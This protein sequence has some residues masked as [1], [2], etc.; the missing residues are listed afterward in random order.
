MKTKFLKLSVWLT[1]AMILAG[2]SCKGKE[3]VKEPD[4]PSL[5]V[6]PEVKYPYASLR[7]VSRYPYGQSVGIPTDSQ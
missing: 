6:T 2:T 4:A 7:I 5:S 3:V 1:A